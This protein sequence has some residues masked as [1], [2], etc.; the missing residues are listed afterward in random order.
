MQPV[1]RK[2]YHTTNKIYFFTAT[3]H[4]WLP[5]LAQDNNQQLII[6][7]LKTL[8]DK[9]LISVYAFVLMPNHLHMIW[10]QNKLMEKKRRRAAF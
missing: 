10:R 5:L 2:S 7:Y 6:D 1:Q 4:K 3:I 8:S 9:G